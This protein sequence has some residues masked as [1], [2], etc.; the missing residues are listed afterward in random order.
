M[1]ISVST[2]NIWV[3]IGAEEHNLSAVSSSWQGHEDTKQME[4]GNLFLYSWLQWAGE[5]DMEKHICT[6][7]LHLTA[8][9]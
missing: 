6:V 1:E 2:V 4:I 9:I 3:C 5:W 8:K 7:S